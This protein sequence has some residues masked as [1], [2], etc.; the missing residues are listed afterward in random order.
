M[1]ADLIACARY[2]TYDVRAKPENEGITHVLF[3]IHLSHHQEKSL[4]VG[5]QGDP[6][7]SVHID[8]L[9]P[10]SDYSITPHQAISSSISKLFLGNR[11]PKEVVIPMDTLLDDGNTNEEEK[12]DESTP[13][14]E[15]DEMQVDERPPETVSE[16]SSIEIDQP[17]PEYQFQVFPTLSTTGVADIAPQYKRLHG[18]IQAA[19]SKL[20]D[21]AKR[22]ATKRV[23]ILVNLIPREPCFPLGMLYVTQLE[24][25]QRSNEIMYVVIILF[26]IEESS[27]LGI[28]VKHIHKVL[29]E[30]DQ[31]W[32]QDENWVLKE[33]MDPRKLQNGGTFRNVL[34]R[35]IDHVLIPIFAEIIACI[36][37][38][39]NLDL[40]D[41]RN[42]NS[43]LSLFWLAMFGS[44]EIMQFSYKEMTVAR[45]QIPGVGGRRSEDDFKCQLPFFWLIKRA[46]DA[47]WDNVKSTSGNV[48]LAVGCVMHVIELLYSLV[49]NHMECAIH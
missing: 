45:K 42:E 43:P 37:R 10:T 40:M 12:M 29:E 2:R 17:E 11:S 1:N 6:W 24:F 48:Y 39:Y 5:F 28:L 27:F 38:N 32:D 35:K 7:I 3:I 9:R 4:F 16:T 13:L 25:Y 33:A 22:R 23:E 34:A 21:A 26:G 49:K 15:S 30:R 19:A 46:I 41:S 14:T 36:D 31:I 20:Q 8:D 44:P 18:C 47:Q